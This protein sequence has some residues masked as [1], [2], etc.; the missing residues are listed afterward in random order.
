[1]TDPKDAW[2]VQRRQFL[3]SSAA[4]AAGLGFSSSAFG[5]ICP[6]KTGTVRDRLWVFCNPRNADYNM[7]RQ[8]SVM[9]PLESAVYFGIPNIHMVNQYPGGR[10]TSRPGEEGWYQA[11]APP[12][13]QYAVPLEVLKRVVWSIVGAS[14]VTSESERRQVLDMALHTPNCVGVYMDDFFRNKPD[15]KVASLSLDQ[16]KHIQQ[17]LKGSTRKLDLYVTLYTNQ[18]TPSIADYLNL[19]DVVSLW[20][21]DN[22]DLGN[23]EANLTRLE[24]LAPRSRKL[25]GCYTSAYNKNQTPAWTG[26]PV[27]AMQKQC[28]TALRLLRSGRIDGI[29]IYGCTT[30][31]LDWKSVE[32]TREWIQSVGDTKL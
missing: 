31:D 17:E 23:L 10:E 1:M 3:Q 14:G 13:Q 11:W 18:L 20:T 30:T 29:V 24:R 9:S 15:P 7:V 32:W 22:S 6:P 16:L 2:K 4:V 27:P 25:L 5:Q 21:W 19:I 12:F 26:L 28:E 8:R